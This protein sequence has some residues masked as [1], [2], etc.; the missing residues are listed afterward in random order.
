MQIS[1]LDRA[2]RGRLRTLSKETAE[3]VGRHLVMA[4]RLIDSDPELAYE[5]AQAAVRRAGRVDVAREAAGLTAY[6]TGRYAE[7]LRELRTVRRLNGS[8]EHLPIMA[9][10]ERGLGRP[11]RALALAASEEAATLDDVGRTEL[12]IVVSGA[13]VDLGEL[14]A[15][16]AALEQVPA[17]GTRGELGARVLQARAAVLEVAGRDDEAAEILAGIDASLLAAV[18]GEDDD[19]VVYDL[20]E[21]VDEDGDAV[22]EPLDAEAAQAPDHTAS[23]DETTESQDE[24]QGAG[25]DDSE[26]A[27]APSD[28]AG[29]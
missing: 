3:V 2:A 14:D 11:E 7:A 9:D 5:H 28:E 17:I 29:R 25:H 18:L 10:C 23:A 15:A 13:R 26:W 27:S 8:S 19:V 1:Q 16:L 6:A 20:T 4:G 21:E 12:A 22:A 24:E